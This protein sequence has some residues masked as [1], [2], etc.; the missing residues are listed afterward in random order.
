MKKIKLKITYHRLDAL[1]RLWDWAL[2]VE[3]YNPTERM[4]NKEYKATKNLLSKV[5]KRLQK[6]QIDKQEGD[7]FTISFE[8]FEVYFLVRF[9]SAMVGCMHPNDQ[10]IMNAYIIELDQKL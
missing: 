10:V 5:F 8:Y 7:K 9:I 3:N 1:C 2:Q 6:K 4:L